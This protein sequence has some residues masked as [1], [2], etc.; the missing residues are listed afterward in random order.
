MQS[1]S[2]PHAP[3][4]MSTPAHLDYGGSNWRGGVITADERA[5]RFAAQVQAV[6]DARAA[7]P[8]SGL[9]PVWDWRALGAAADHRQALFAYDRRFALAETFA[10][11]VGLSSAM[12]LSA[13]HRRW[14]GASHAHSPG[15][16]DTDGAADAEDRRRSHL[17]KKRALLGPLR[18]ADLPATVDFVRAYERFVCEHVCPALHAGLAADAGGARDR[19]LFQAFPCV[20]VQQPSEYPTIRP[21]MDR[22]YGHPPGTLNVWVPLTPAGDSNTLWTES[23]PGKQDFHPLPRLEVGQGVYGDMANCTHFTQANA[24]DVT[25]VSLDFRVVPRPDYDSA[26]AALPKAEGHGGG[27]CPFRLGTYYSEAVRRADG[28]FEVAI[29][30]S[31][32]RQHGF[33]H[34]N[35]PQEP[36]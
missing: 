8:H 20:R 22:M 1:S 35:Q 13:V 30:G 32:S 5:Q 28:T 29:R 24:S 6:E 25:R 19:L 33:P 31:P 21:H 9:P 16:G 12:E 15:A 27:E 7:D 3:D 26:S 23:G 4:P 10:A 17:D 11:A 34:T 2:P 36:A 14:F 18:D